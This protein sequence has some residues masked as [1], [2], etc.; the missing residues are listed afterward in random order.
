MTWAAA[1][2]RVCRAAAYPT[3]PT[4]GE[5]ISRLGI[6]DEIAADLPRP[7][8][9]RAELPAI[10]TGTEPDGSAPIEFWRRLSTD[11]DV[12]WDRGRCSRR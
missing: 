10:A 1:P 5:E 2:Q 4:S 8:A 12:A 9:T 7:A 3:R 6:H 11:T